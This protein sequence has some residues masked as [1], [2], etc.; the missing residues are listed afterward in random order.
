MN[1]KNT[2][3]FIFLTYDRNTKTWYFIHEV[4]DE[5]RYESFRQAIDIHIMEFLYYQ[6]TLRENDTVIVYNVYG[7]EIIHKKEKS[8]I[9]ASVT[10]SKNHVETM[11]T[12]RYLTNIYT[13]ALEFFYKEKTANIILFTYGETPLSG[14]YSYELTENTFYFKKVPDYITAE[15]KLKINYNTLYTIFMKM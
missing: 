4:R 2:E 1:T 5:K 10:S 11:F 14:K 8:L 3:L 13:M 6:N 7:T 15:S 12:E 9:R